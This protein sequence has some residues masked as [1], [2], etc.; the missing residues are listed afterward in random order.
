MPPSWLSSLSQPQAP[1]SSYVSFTLDQS[2]SALTLFHSYAYTHDYANFSTPAGLKHVYTG[3]TSSVLFRASLY[4]APPITLPLRNRQQMN[5]NDQDYE[6]DDNSMPDLE[7]TT[8]DEDD[9][10]Q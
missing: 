2:A 9:S 1:A 4:Q 6:D 5:E 7:Q 3:A 10:P 8:P